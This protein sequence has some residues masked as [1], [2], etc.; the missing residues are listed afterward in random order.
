MSRRGYPRAPAWTA[1]E[2]RAILAR[3]EAQR[4]EG[5]KPDWRTLAR[6][7]GRSIQAVAQRASK[8]RS[9]HRALQSTG[10][11]VCSRCGKLFAYPN[12]QGRS[13]LCVSCFASADSDNA[14][15]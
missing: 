3:M 6:D 14:P 12:P 13:M 9:G 10:S 2:D 15:W 11:R 5:A 1:A 8:L 4:L 7:I